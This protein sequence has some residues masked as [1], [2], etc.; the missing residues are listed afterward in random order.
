[1]LAVFIVAARGLASIA[2]MSSSP[3]SAA[4]DVSTSIAAVR[5][6]RGTIVVDGVLDEPTWAAAAAVSQLRKADPIEEGDPFGRC[7][8]RVLH[9]DEALYVA[10][11]VWQP[12]GVLRAHLRPRDDLA[13]EDSVNVY[14]KPQE[15]TNLSYFFR[16]NALAIQRD[17]LVEGP[18]TLHASWDVAWQSAARPLDDGYAV[19]LRLPFA[20]FRHALDDPQDW[21]IGLGVH[22]GSLRQTDLWP[23]Y[24]SDRG[25]QTAQFGT[26]RGISGI[27]EGRRVAVTPSVVARAWATQSPGGSYRREEPP[28]VRMRQ[29][30]VVDPGLD[31][32]YAVTPLATLS[33][34]VNPDYSQVVADA[35]QVDYNVRY[36]LLLPEKRA[37]FLEG[38]SDY[39][40]PVP[41]L[42]TRG[43]NDPIA[44]AKLSGA[45]GARVT[46]G[47]LATWDQDPPP[48]RIRVDPSQ[49]LTQSGFEDMAGKDAATAVARV[50]VNVAGTGRVGAFVAEKVAVDRSGRRVARNELVS[51]D[52]RWNP[53]QVW[54]VLAQA[55]TSRTER[56]GEDA[57]GGAF[58]FVNVRREDRFLRLE[59]E[60]A[61]Y[62][63]D[64][65]A[66]TSD[67]SRTG[68]APSRAA[69]AYKFAVNHRWLAY[70][71]PQLSGNVALDDKW[72][73]VLE[74]S[75]E[76][77]VSAQ[78]GENAVLSATWK[79]GEESFLGHR[80]RVSRS[81]VSA[82]SS[83][84]THV[85]LV[86][87]AS[88]GSQ[89]NYDPADAFL[90]ST[91]EASALARVR[92]TRGLEIEMEYAKSVFSRPVGR[93]V[94]ANVDLAQV[95]LMHAFDARWS[96]RLV[97]QLNTYRRSLRSSALLAWIVRPDTLLFLGYQ[98]VDG[99]TSSSGVSPE[100]AAFLKLSY[101]AALF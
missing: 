66:E 99:T 45:A 27:K 47:L 22:T 77:S 32:R 89:I 36:P 59:A 51:L 54:Y 92:P 26:L 9:D 65:R 8:F 69:A 63:Q 37:F 14:L 62:Q 21:K 41:L 100:R 33:A 42:Y 56:T 2:I 78:V 43:V 20:I 31:V 13:G 64:L 12:P 88:R 44:G 6:P 48:S 1:M 68:H 23:P 29:P 52:A 73:R 16:V 7:E 46:V 3:S 85:E 5:V 57:F 34:T 87:S 30:G 84:S 76:P 98:Q 53:G 50:G 74:W 49:A 61:L 28:L 17:V 40:T 4:P 97:S 10:A 55:G 95:R 72:G 19:E 91:V 11:R 90:G 67:L 83:L 70:V 60:T 25:P 94:A 24:S 15:G 96:V 35:D 86:V 80:Y 82:Q 93:G 79:R 38:L 81:E 39:E 71:R 58:Y 18:E 75:G 101:G